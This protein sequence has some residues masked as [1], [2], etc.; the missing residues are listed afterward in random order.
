[1]S[2]ALLNAMRQQ[3]SL[4]N[5]RTAI[6]KLGIVTSYDPKSYCI[7]ASLEPLIP[8]T[9]WLAYL[10]AVAG[11]QWGFFTPPEIGSQ[12]MVLFHEGNVEAGVA[13]GSMFSTV[14]KPLAVP[15]GEFW[16]VHKQG[17]RFKFTNDGKVEIHGT[18]EIDIGNTGSTLHKLVTDAFVS[19]F[20]GH[21]HSGVQTGGGTSGAPTATM[22][23]SHLTGILKAN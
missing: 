13:I 19:F 15:A 22:D 16:L 18:V 7:K 2:E 1:M 4:A 23:A 20:N 21:T 9:G 14:D 10:S 5:S 12:V 6:A 17:S 8:E 3:A 11:N